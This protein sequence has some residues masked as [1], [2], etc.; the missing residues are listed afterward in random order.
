MWVDDRRNPLVYLKKKPE[1]GNEILQANLDFYND[2]LKKYNPQF[3][4]VKSFE[5]F[6]NYILQNG[7]PDFVSFDRDLGKGLPNGEVCASWLVK[8]CNEK[9]L[10]LPNYYAHTANKNGKRN[11]IAIMDNTPQ[12]MVLNENDI[13]EMVSKVLELVCEDV[14]ANK[15]LFNKKKNAIGL[16]YASGKQKN[17]GNL[18]STDMLKTDKMDEDNE[19]TYEV[20]LKGNIPS[21][22]IVSIK[23]ESVMHYFK[24]KFSK[25]ADSAKIK[26]AGNEYELMMDEPEFQKFSNMFNKKVNRVV[27]FC[28]NKFKKE[29]NDFAPNKVSI[30]PVPSSSNFNE[31]MAK[32]MSKMTLGNLP[33]QIANKDILLK[34]LRNLKKDE[35]FIEKNKKYFSSKMSEKS[36]QNG[37]DNPISNFIDRDINKFKAIND[38]KKY[39]EEMNIAVNKILSALQNY[40]QTKSKT[41]LNSLVQN[42]KRYYDAMKSCTHKVHYINP[43]KGEGEDSKLFLSTVA[44]ALKYTKGPSVEGRS[45][46][47]WDLVK[48]HLRGEKSIDG[49]PY[50]KVDI[51]KWEP[52]KFQIK[53]LSNGERMGLRNYYNPNE[54]LEFLQNEI[55]KIKGGVL[56][57]FDDNISGGATLGDICYQFKDLGVEYLIPITFGKMDTKWQFG[58]VPLNQPEN[59]MGIKG[60]FNY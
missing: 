13:I 33:V 29:Q 57:I 15:S 26:I 27:N 6:K 14:F 8:Y 45:G 50:K 35:D 36:V 20:K 7:L 9:G 53:N 39:I 59:D 48:K 54:D 4:W 37:F 12:Q 25:K 24:N 42:Y 43:V 56:V 3:T 58:M 31:I 10:R 1:E 41:T 49:T 44:S 11:I 47:I 19:D 34:D 23:G 21:Y 51:N 22:N 17:K 18:T 30:Y 5:E 46:I 60:E 32:S 55:N 38:A 16:T 52:Q 40:K 2:F 28:I